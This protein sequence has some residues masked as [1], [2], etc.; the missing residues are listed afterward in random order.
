MLGCAMVPALRRWREAQVMLV[1]ST[2]QLRVA[3]KWQRLHPSQVGLA[4]E[5]I[6][7]LEGCRSAFEFYQQ[8]TS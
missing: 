3:D 2:R 1:P 7:Y 8:Y 5:N 6:S 4:G